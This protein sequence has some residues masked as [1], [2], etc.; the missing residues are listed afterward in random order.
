MKLKISLL[1][2]KY[3][4]CER[5]AFELVFSNLIIQG[6]VIMKKI[7]KTVIVLTAIRV[8]ISTKSKNNTKDTLSAKEWRV[9][10]KSKKTIYQFC[11][12]PLQCFLE[13]LNQA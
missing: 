6:E 3:K 1:Q 2:R 5:L 11:E 4:T 13:A 12:I 9:I 8:A 10:N 7:L